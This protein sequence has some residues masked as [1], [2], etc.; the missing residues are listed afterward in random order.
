MTNC[1]WPIAQWAEIRWWRRYLKRKPPEAYLAWK[2]A[3][4]KSFIQRLEIPLAPG[5]RALDAGCGPA[6]IFIALND[7]RVDALDPLL[8]AYAELDHFQPEKY[9]WASFLP[10]GLEYFDRENAY[11]L[12]F[13]LNAINHMADV[14]TA[15]QRLWLALKKEGHA[16]ISVDAHR[17]RLLKWSFQR[18]PADVLHPFQEDLEG[19][20][21]LLEKAGFSVV[22]ATLYEKGHIFDYWVFHLQKQS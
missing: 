2:T 3:Y 19:Y 14:P 11:D 5:M 17:Y 4:W 15:L 13:C 7:C 21:A 10:E 6:G 9:P 22:S 12:V 1:Q 16:Y 18:I 20:Q 8:P